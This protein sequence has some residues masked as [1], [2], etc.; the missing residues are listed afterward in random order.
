MTTMEVYTL[1]E[2]GKSLNSLAVFIH[3][4]NKKWWTDLET[5]EPLHRNVGEMLMLM[6]SELSEA[7]EGHRKN[8]M[9]D[10]LPDRKMIEVEMADSIIRHLDFCA[11]MGLDIGGAL[12]DKL[13][14]NEVRQDHTAE[15][16]KAE[17]GKKY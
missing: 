6:V 1:E 16:R 9:D 12:V 3:H 13:C 7:M 4:L 11:G 15:A 14:Y 5:G 10:H 17:N 8:L 2:R